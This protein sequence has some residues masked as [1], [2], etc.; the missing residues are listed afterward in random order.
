MDVED[1]IDLSYEKFAISN[2]SREEITV[3][4]EIGT[5]YVTLGRFAYLSTTTGSL[6][7][8]VSAD[9]DSEQKMISAH[10]LTIAPLPWLSLSAWESV[11]FG[12]RFELAYLSPVSLYI[13]SQMGIAGDKDNSTMGFDFK[14]NLRSLGRF[15]GSLYINEIEHDK[16]DRLFTYPK[17]MFAYYT[18]FKP[19]IKSL[20]RIRF[21]LFAECRQYCRCK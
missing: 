9:S 14:A 7:H 6:G 4:N 3:S 19:S 1:R 2:R 18:G 16:L 21:F 15:Y 10:K 13:V 5:N 8:T 20:C 11:I 12:K 17:N